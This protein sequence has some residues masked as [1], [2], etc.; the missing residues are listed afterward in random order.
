VQRKSPDV[1]IHAAVAALRNSGGTE[2]GPVFEALTVLTRLPWRVHAAVIETAL[3][4]L[5]SVDSYWEEARLMHQ[6]RFQLRHAPHCGER[7]RWV[8]RE[9]AATPRARWPDL[10]LLLA[11]EIP[12]L[13]EERDAPFVLHC[14]Y[15]YA[16]AWCDGAE[17]ARRQDQTWSVLDIAPP[18]AYLL[19]E[20]LLAAERVTD[21]DAGGR[22]AVS[23]LGALDA[24]RMGLFAM[25]LHWEADDDARS[26][27]VTALL[28]QLTRLASRDADVFARWRLANRAAVQAQLSTALVP[29]YADVNSGLRRVTRYAAM[30]NSNPQG[31]P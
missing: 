17:E 27:Q 10:V 31:T 14:L 19:A 1:A 22:Y 23:V 6:L 16:T 13:V 11:H 26:A 30:F 3:H 21:D 18:A 8:H 15:R 12:A 25:Q 5:R 29:P 9:V 28:R 7:V 24:R 4:Q 2:A 20:L